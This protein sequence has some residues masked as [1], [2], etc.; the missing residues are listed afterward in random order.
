MLFPAERFAIEDPDRFKKAIAVKKG[1]I[2]HGD[3][4]FFFGNKSAIEKN[5]H[6]SFYRKRDGR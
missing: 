4:R 3:D 2:K 1:A 6:A 5:E